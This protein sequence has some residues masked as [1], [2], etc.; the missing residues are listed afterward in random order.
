MTAAYSITLILIMA[1]QLLGYL[2][3]VKGLTQATWHTGIISFT[4]VLRVYP[5]IKQVESKQMYWIVQ[6]VLLALVVVYVMQAV[7]VSYCIRVGKFFF[8]FPVNVLRELSCLFIWILL[9][10][11]AEMFFSILRCESGYHEVDTG[12]KCWHGIHI[13]YCI[14][15]LISLAVFLAINFAIAILFNESRPRSADSLRRLDTNLELNLLIFRIAIVITSDLSVNDV[16]HWFLTLLYVFGFFYW[17]TVCLR[18]LPFYN[19]AVSL[20]YGM[21]ACS[22]LWAALNVVAAKCLQRTEYSGM[23]ILVV[24]GVGFVG[25]MVLNGRTWRINRILFATRYDKFAQ[26]YELDLYLTNILRLLD[27]Q[28]KDKVAQ[29][30]LL[31]ILSHHKNECNNPDCPLCFK[32]E[33]YLP[34]TETSLLVSPS[35]LDNPV[36]VLHLVAAIY[37]VYARNSKFKAGLHISYSNFLLTYIGNIHMAILELYLAEKM[38]PSM[39]QFFTIHRS[40]RL[41]ER[42]LASHKTLDVGN[43]MRFEELYSKLHRAAERAAVHHIE[44]WMQLNS[45][46]PDLDQLHKLGLRIM[47]YKRLVEETWKQLYEINSKHCKALKNHGMYLKIICNDD[48]TG[49]E[50]MEKARNLSSN[51]LDNK[52]ELEVAFAEDTAIVV[53]KAGNSE[54]QGKI[55]NTNTGMSV[56]FRYNSM[57]V[58]GQYVNIFMPRSISAKHNEFLEDYFNT[59]KE[60]LLNNK[61][62]VYAIR[63]TGDLFCVSILV[64]LVPSLQ[65]DIEYL[66]IIRERCKEHSFILTDMYGRIDSVSESLA[67]MLEM[68]QSFFKENE[69][70]VQLLFPELIEM[71]KEK[72]GT[73]SAKI[74]KLQGT[75]KLTMIVPRD[76]GQTIQDFASQSMMAANKDVSESALP[77]SV[78]RVAQFVHGDEYGVE[79]AAG[80]NALGQAVDYKAF[81]FKAEFNV[82]VGNLNYG[83]GKCR[84]KVFKIATSKAGDSMDEERNSEKCFDVQVANNEKSS[85]KLHFNEKDLRSSNSGFVMEELKHMSQS[86]DLLLRKKGTITNVNTNE[87]QDESIQFIKI[88]DSNRGSMEAPSI[89]LVENANDTSQC[90]DYSRAELLDPT[91]KEGEKKSAKSP[92]NEKYLD[93]SQ[94]D[95]GERNDIIVNLMKSNENFKFAGNDE[96]KGKEGASKAPAIDD[97]LSSIVTSAKSLINH[98]RALRKATYEEYCPTSVLQL[99]YVGRFVFLFL[100]VIALINFVIT[101]MLYSNLDHNVENIHYTRDRLIYITSLG[102]CTRTLVLLNSE[103]R[104]RIDPKSRSGK[105]YHLDGFEGY[106]IGAEELSY[107]GWLFHCVEEAARQAKAAQNGLSTATF[108]FSAKSREMINP[109]HIKISYKEEETGNIML[110]CWSAVMGLVAHGLRVKDMRLQDISFEEGSVYYVVEN[111]LNNVL[112][113]IYTSIEGVQDASEKTSDDNKVVLAIL[114]SIASAAIVISAAIIFRVIL[115]VNNNE[116][117]I[118][119]LFIEIPS[120]NAKEQLSRCKNYYM[121][122]HSADYSDFTNAE[123]DISELEKQEA[124]LEGD[125]QDEDNDEEKKLIGRLHKAKERKYKPYSAKSVSQIAKF[126]IFVAIIE[127]YFLTC[128]FTS[129]SFLA[130]AKSLILELVTLSSQSYHTGCLYK[131]F[132][133]YIGSDGKAFIR[134]IS[135]ETH[136]VVKFPEFIV[137]HKSFLQEHSYNTK[138]TGKEYDRLFSSVVYGDLCEEVFAGENCGEFPIL[139]HGLDAAIVSYWNSLTEAVYYFMSNKNDT[140]KLDL[141]VNTFNETEVIAAERMSKKHFTRAFKAVIQGLDENITERFNSGNTVV[142]AL[143][144]SFSVF[145]CL[146]YAIIWRLFVEATRNSL[147]E[148]KCML[149]I[150]PITTILESPSI[151]SYLFGSAKGLMLSMR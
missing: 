89:F 127:A 45:L 74:D 102:S 3:S 118:L 15:F 85:T 120:K 1:F 149:T 72:D 83:N 70:Y 54:T 11:V 53:M 37:K 150:L 46:L 56:L 129:A 103:T 132:Q 116:E 32:K 146:L 137:R 94:Q 62:E 134:G 65:E 2:F 126:F 111:S 145:V 82:T 81:K 109:K 33:L 77:E 140:T 133:D 138:V 105:D 76:L 79:A 125:K 26:E 23:Y 88:A 67:G 122:V 6:Y 124:K 64:K 96:G 51:N 25:L 14:L 34:A 99:I 106:P 20:V 58:L 147:W 50:L 71:V 36:L 80:F 139:R 131:I 151:K 9:I 117:C 44:F 108:P 7:Y 75:N 60:R 144:I 112:N 40:K 49:D 61:S 92:G 86:F 148:T 135:T 90:L 68:S 114:V 57:E 8:E 130:S 30:S 38:G 4:N 42:H 91:L 69:V 95:I 73:L 29:M 97:E 16:Y 31:G 101:K 41:I 78:K 59:G 47:E 27:A 141:I 13:F 48:E 39:Q 113:G 93:K 55:A 119:K 52:S 110:D 136:A 128:Y 12:L 142:M 107:D 87:V 22:C 121:V 18:K 84:L 66:A 24:F 104:E 63:R 19:T 10:P 98:L 35:N 143:F 123:F 43:V 28:V 21:G 5:G 17:A 100:F 115:M